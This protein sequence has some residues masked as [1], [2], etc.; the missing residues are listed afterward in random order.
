MTSSDDTTMAPSEAANPPFK[1]VTSRNKSKWLKATITEATVVKQTHSFT[2]C[3]YFPPLH[4]NTKFNLTASMR[5]SLTELVKH[6]PSILIV[7]L[8]DKTQLIVKQDLLDQFQETFYSLDQCA[9][10]YKT[11]AYY[12][13]LPHDEQAYNLR[14]QIQ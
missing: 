6:E 14:D 10:C 7:N 8:I 11:A 12:H 5:T 3:I 9:C 2:I 1:T 13:W 4:A